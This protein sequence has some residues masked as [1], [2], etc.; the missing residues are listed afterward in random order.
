MDSKTN[1]RLERD[2]FIAEACKIDPAFEG[3]LK[4][5]ED[6]REKGLVVKTGFKFGSHFRAY[7][8]IESVKRIPH[9]LYLV[10]FVENGHE[11]ILPDLS[12]S[13]RLANSVRKEMVFAYDENGIHYFSVGRIKL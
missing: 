3:K 2:G 5:Y 10:D 12:R 13:V 7:E 6:L 8:R 1:E 11:F 9:S 4:V